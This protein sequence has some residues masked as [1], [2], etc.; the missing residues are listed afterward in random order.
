[1]VATRCATPLFIILEIIVPIFGVKRRVEK[2]L[3]VCRRATQTGARDAFESSIFT[4][5]RFLSSPA[6]FSWNGSVMRRLALHAR[7]YQA[8]VILVG[9]W[10]ATHQKSLESFAAK[11]A[12]PEFALDVF[13]WKWPRFLVNLAKA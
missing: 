7:I 4:R 8:C 6:A 2:K 3:P 11:N 9:Y 12:A 13:H 5:F 10:I 1:M